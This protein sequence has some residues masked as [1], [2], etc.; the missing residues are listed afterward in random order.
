[1]QLCAAGV[2]PSLMIKHMAVA[3][4]AHRMVMNPENILSGENT[5]DVVRQLLKD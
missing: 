2:M 3:S 1:M 5:S 4:L